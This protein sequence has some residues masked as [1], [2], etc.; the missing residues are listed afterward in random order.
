MSDARRALPTTLDELARALLVVEDLPP[1]ERAARLRRLVDPAKSILGAAGDAAVSEAC[2]TIR[3]A[4]VARQLGVGDAAVSNARK[5][6]AA[7]TGPKVPEP[8]RADQVD[9]Q[10]AGA[11][12]R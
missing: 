3:P 11:G 8:R 6:H 9:Q 7:R 1:V 5:R 2:R 10:P 4:E 12:T